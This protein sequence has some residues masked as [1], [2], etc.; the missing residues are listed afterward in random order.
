M[1]LVDGESV[2]VAAEALDFV[3]A[4]VR[5]YTDERLWTKL[6]ANGLENVKQNFSLDAAALHV[7]EDLAKGIAHVH[8]PQPMNTM[9][10]RF[11]V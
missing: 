11:G 9:A 3:R 5:L 8:L 6:S 4:V 2:L 7:G 10:V 1:H